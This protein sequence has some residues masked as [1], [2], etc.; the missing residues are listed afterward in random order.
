MKTCTRQYFL[1]QPQSALVP[2][3]KYENSQ[4]NCFFCV[5]QGLWLVLFF[6]CPRFIPTV[7]NKVDSHTDAH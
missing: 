1:T 6:S 2:P 5:P 3:K 7:D 4:K